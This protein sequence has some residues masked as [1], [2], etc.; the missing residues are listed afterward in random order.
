MHRERKGGECVFR[1]V[2]FW[3]EYQARKTILTYTQ[4]ERLFSDHCWEIVLLPKSKDDH[5]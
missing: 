5:I 2:L 1:Q 3:L 4:T